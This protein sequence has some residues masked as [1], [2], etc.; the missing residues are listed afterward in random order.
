MKL[1]HVA[2]LVLAILLFTVIVQNTS[3]TVVHILFWKISMSLIL[4]IL[5][6]ALA[7]FAIG[8]LVHHL[9]VCRSRDKE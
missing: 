3:I 8:F 4:L 7:G 5:F 1:P 2:I 9:T 6:S